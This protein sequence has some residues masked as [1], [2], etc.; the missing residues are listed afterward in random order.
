MGLTPLHYAA[1]ASAH[2]SLAVAQ[3]LITLGRAVDPGMTA[4]GFRA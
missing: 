2:S 3:M 1:E 4:L